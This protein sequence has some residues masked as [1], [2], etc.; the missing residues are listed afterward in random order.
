MASET[1]FDLSKYRKLGTPQLKK[2][3]AKILIAAGKDVDDFNMESYDRDGLL[4]MVRHWGGRLGG[5]AEDV[6]DEGEVDVPTPPK[7][8]GRRT[9]QPKFDVESP[10]VVNSVRYLVTSVQSVDGGFTYDLEGKMGPVTGVPETDLKAWKEP[11][12]PKSRF[13]LGDQVRKDDEFQGEVI[14]SSHNLALGG[15]VYV[16]KVTEDDGDYR[17]EAGVAQADL[18]KV[19][20]TK[21][22]APKA[23]RVRR[24]ADDVVV[25]LRRM[26]VEDGLSYAKLAGWLAETHGVQVTGDLVRSITIGEIYKHVPL[27]V[28]PDGETADDST[29]DTSK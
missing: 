13:V 26:R 22:K 4:D 1:S 29:E 15:W 28:A 2:A 21:P 17:E 23:E 11:R 10:V 3:L 16:I 20:A 8:T 9:R 19:R 27:Y 12:V 24:I 6:S 5:E 7:K 25:E 14:D 18:R